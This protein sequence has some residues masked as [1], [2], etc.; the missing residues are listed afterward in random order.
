M[1][2]HVEIIESLLE[3]TLDLGKTNYEIAKLKAIDK[4]VDIVSS[5]IPHWVVIVIL[6]SALLFLNV[7]AALWLGDLLGKIYFGFM[8]VGAFY[9]FVGIIIHFFFHKGIKNRCSDFF[10]QQLLK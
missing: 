6:L 5:F 1:E 7:A 10:I 3:K 8:T 2:N 4:T 9:V